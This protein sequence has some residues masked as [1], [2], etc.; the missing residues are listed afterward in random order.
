MLFCGAW[1]LQYVVQGATLWGMS[2]QVRLSKDVSVR[3]DALAVS[4]RRSFAN[5][6]EVLLLGAL[7]GG[8]AGAGGTV[9]GNAGRERLRSSEA[10][11]APM[12]GSAPPVPASPS[13][14]AHMKKHRPAVQCATLVDE[15]E[16]P[17]CGTIVDNA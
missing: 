11:A 8:L 12:R 3:V 9:G 15:G 1:C 7:D 2:K 4:E 6:V 16:C 10:V 14:R 17:D 5:M 13:V